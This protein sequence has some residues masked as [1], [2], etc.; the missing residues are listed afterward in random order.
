MNPRTDKKCISPRRAYI[1]VMLAVLMWGV[2]FTLM[3]VSVKE[4][5][6]FLAVWLRV[7]FALPVFV[8]SIF[9]RRTFRMPSFSEL[10]V[11]TFMGG[12]GITL[13]LS[14]QFWAMLS[15][16]AANANWML[17]A[18]PSLV[19]LLGWLVLKEGLSL[20]SIA[21]MIVSGFGVLLVLGMGT[22]GLGFFSGFGSFGDFLVLLSVLNWAVFQ[23]TSR[24]ITQRMDP[25][26]SIF[27]MNV[28]ALFLQTV[29]VF[30]T[31]GFSA[32]YT[33]LSAATWGSL[34]LMGL[35]C[36]GLAYVCWYDAL[37]VLPVARVTVFQFAQ[38]LI[39][40]VTSY[41]ILGERFTFYLLLGGVMIFSGILLVNKGRSFSK[42]R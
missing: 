32:P 19:A 20:V 9:M 36:S 28:M 15:S 11:L 14:L 33:G 12:A 5:H 13:Q 25:A 39:G 4:L 34:L 42:K 21:G 31:C 7:L 24:R 30:F 6:P 40:A 27:W 18:T 29:I 2:S 26:F 23:I 35:F 37:S 10:A 1:G 38:P 17:A 3:K 41:F 22:V 8:V 16:G